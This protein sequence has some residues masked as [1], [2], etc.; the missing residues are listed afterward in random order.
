MEATPSAST[1]QQGREL[2]QLQGSWE[3]TSLRTLSGFTSASS[4]TQLFFLQTEET[5]D[6][7]QDTPNFCRCTNKSIL[8]GCITAPPSP[9]NL[10]VGTGSLYG[11]S[12]ER[13]IHP[14][15]GSTP[16]A[17]GGRPVGLDQTP[18]CPATD[19]SLVFSK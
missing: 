5:Q 12:P 6:G 19:R 7:L 13:S 4:Q 11:T 8:T 1:A 9:G 18:S 17:A 15:R 2:E 3:F 10:G 14:W 16:R